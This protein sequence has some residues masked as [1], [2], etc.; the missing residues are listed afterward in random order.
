MPGSLTQPEA[1][2][3]RRLTLAIAVVALALLAGVGQVS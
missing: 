3:P 2:R 1:R